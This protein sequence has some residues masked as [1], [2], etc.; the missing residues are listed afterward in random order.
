MI[1]AESDANTK[2]IGKGRRSGNVP[3]YFSRTWM[4]Y[5][6]LLLPTAFFIIFR[7]IPM[8]YIWMAFSDFNIF[9]TEGLFGAYGLFSNQW[10]GLVHFRT[11]FGQHDFWPAFRNTLTLNVLDLVVGFPAPII[12]AILLNE[13][14]FGIF[15]KFTQT[16]LYMPHFLSWVVV[17]AM[18]VQLFATNMGLLNDFLN[19]IGL[20]RVNFLMDSR[21]WVITYIGLGVWKSAGWGT[22][23][24]LAAIAGIN[25]ELYEAAEVDGANRFKKII[26]VTVPCLLPTIIILFILNVG[27]MIGIEFDRPFVLQNDMV[28]DVGDVL[29]TYVFRRGIQTFQYSLATAVGVFQS[30][31]NIILLVTANQLAKHAG[32]R[33][34]F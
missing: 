22:I 26:H 32:Q 34:L 10:V 2:K 23:I 18:V 33:G 17:S 24:Y 4:L 31:I 6:M 28:M 1:A 12:I 15:K 5:V 21:N 30:F 13:L 9:R 7:Y 14:K 3:G 19:N 20:S 8:L 27:S 29:S 25:Q 16:V 11:A